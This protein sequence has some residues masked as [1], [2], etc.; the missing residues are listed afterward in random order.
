MAFLDDLIYTEDL[1]LLVVFPQSDRSIY[2]PEEK[3]GNPGSNKR[4]MPHQQ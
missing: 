2:A 4:S 1:L 3:F